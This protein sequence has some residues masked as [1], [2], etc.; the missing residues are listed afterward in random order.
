MAKK[1][2]SKINI[3]IQSEKERLIKENE[4]KKLT[5]SSQL[6][7]YIEKVEQNSKDFVLERGPFDR[8]VKM[9]PYDVKLTSMSGIPYLIKDYFSK[10][11]SF[12][13]ILYCS[14]D[15]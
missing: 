4:A 13:S 5:L 11:P 6:K 2:E 15:Y 8:L 3:N 10:W 7:I 1:E 9:M 14:L 12:T